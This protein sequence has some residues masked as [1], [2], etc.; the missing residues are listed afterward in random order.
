MLKSLFCEVISVEYEFNSVKFK[1][2]SIDLKMNNLD[3][4]WKHNGIQKTLP[5]RPRSH[6]YILFFAMKSVKICRFKTSL[7]RIFAR[8][9]LFP[10][11]YFSI[12]VKIRVLWTHSAIK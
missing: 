5:T 8:R 6:R 3:L 4:A 9:T 2:G 1:G 7:L 10:F 12:H 11:R